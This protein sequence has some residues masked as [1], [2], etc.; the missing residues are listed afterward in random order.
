MPKK[1]RQSSSTRPIPP[2]TI[3]MFLNVFIVSIFLRLRPPRIFPQT[4]WTVL[5]NGRS[6]K[7]SEQ[8]VFHF[9]DFPS[10]RLWRWCL[11]FRNKSG[12]RPDCPRE[13]RR[14]RPLRAPERNGCGTRGTH[15][16]IFCTEIARHAYATGFGQ[17]PPAGTCDVR[18]GL[19]SRSRRTVVS[20]PFK[21]FESWKTV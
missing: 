2:S 5:R 4:P 16:A 17:E 8:I 3:R 20:H 1:S 19:L 21:F 6:Y 10:K 7:V 15:G 9:T 13:R 14:G 12:I 11:P 18:R